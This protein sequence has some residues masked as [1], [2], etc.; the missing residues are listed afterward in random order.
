LPEEKVEI[1]VVI[2]PKVKEDRKEKKPMAEELPKAKPKEENSKSK[3]PE[4]RKA[5]EKPP[6]PKVEITLG[7]HELEY[8]FVESKVKKEKSPPIFSDL[9]LKF[10][11][12]SKKP[13]DSKAKSDH[14]YRA[15][16]KEEPPKDRSES[17]VKGKP[18]LPA[19]KKAETESR[20]QVAYGSESTPTKPKAPFICSFLS[21]WDQSKDQIFNSINSSLTNI[22]KRRAPSVDNDDEDD[23]DNNSPRPESPDTDEYVSNWEDEED[24][25]YLD[26]S[27]EKVM[28]KS[29]EKGTGKRPAV[30]E[31]KPVRMATPPPS[32]SVAGVGLNLNDVLT[33]PK[34]LQ[35]LFELV[36]EDDV[37]AIKE[38]VK[39]LVEAEKRV[40]ESPKTKA[41]VAAKNSKDAVAVVAPPET[42]KLVTGEGGKTKEPKVIVKEIEAIIAPVLAPVEKV[43][44]P[45]K[46]LLP[47]PEKLVEKLADEYE[48]FMKAVNDSSEKLEPDAEPLLF[49]PKL[50]T[51]AVP[52]L[53]GKVKGRAERDHDSSSGNDSSSDSE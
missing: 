52:D 17:R 19:E 47:I 9:S 24:S 30:E 22:K 33:T 51:D 21:D 8:D 2:E 46:P 36:V 15:D 39:K 28:R 3:K 43:S 35:D 38:Q 40:H 26:V 27:Y 7:E 41:V 50:D 5:L 32:S 34:K 6:K 20:S 14:G 1:V 18:D 4:E 23:D 31:V 53:A 13:A 37:A 16:K 44:L 42:E 49:H 25:S 45:D 12:I 48:S 10:E 29:K 11:K